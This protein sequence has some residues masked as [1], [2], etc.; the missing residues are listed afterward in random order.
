[1]ICVFWK[2]EFNSTE[3]K[4]S[5][6]ALGSFQ[7]H[8]YYEP[9]VAYFYTAFYFYCYNYLLHVHC[10]LSAMSCSACSYVI[11]VKNILNFTHFPL[12]FSLTLPIPSSAHT[13]NLYLVLQTNRRRRMMLKQFC[14]LQV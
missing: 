14:F 3:G 4:C 8:P 11:G 13:I 12:S 7:Q 10:L 5:S 2:F 1:M 6:E 9:H